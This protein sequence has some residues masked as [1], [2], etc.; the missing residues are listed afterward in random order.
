MNKP[1]S[2]LLV[3][4]G[5][6]V[7]AAAFTL[8]AHAKGNHAIAWEKLPAAVQKTLSEKAS[9]AKIGEVDMTKKDKQ[10]VYE[11]KLPNADGTVSV[12]DVSADGKIV[13]ETS[14]PAAKDAAPAEKK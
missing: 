11:T 9:D 6:A 12:I 4:A 5:L 3:L 2:K 7:A 8:P 10:S 1:T 14:Q 13:S